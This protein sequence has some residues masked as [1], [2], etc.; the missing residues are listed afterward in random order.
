MGVE[1]AEW[2][3]I[4]DRIVAGF[5]GYEDYKFSHDNSNAEA[6]REAWTLLVEWFPALWD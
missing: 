3:S 2:D 4:L 5:A 6:Q 1:P